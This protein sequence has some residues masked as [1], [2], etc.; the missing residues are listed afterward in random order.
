[1]HLKIG[2]SFHLIP[3]ID[4]GSTASIYKSVNTK[5]GEEVAIKVE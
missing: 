3:K 4:E 2:K 5:T 1:M